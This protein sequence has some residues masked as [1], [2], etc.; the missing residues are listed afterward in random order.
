MKA[1]L[2]P[3]SHNDTRSAIADWMELQALGSSRARATSATLSNVLDITEDEAAETPTIDEETGEILDE[4]ILEEGRWSLVTALFEE[5]EYR[6]QVLGEAYPFAVD[7]RRLIL[8]RTPVDPEAQA[9]QVVYLFC[10]LASAIREKKLKLVEDI[11]A[12]ERGIA[13]AFQICACLAAGGYISGEVTSFG[14]PRQT[15]DGF[16]PALRDAY[17]R[18][19]IGEVRAEIPDGLPE[20]LKDGG[21]DVIAWRDHPDGMPG[22]IYLLGQCA[23]GRNWKSKSVV[24]YIEQLHGSWFTLQPASHS[25]PAMFIPFTFHCDMPEERRGPFLT[26][27]KNAYWY[28]EKRFGIIFDRLRIAHFAHSCMSATDETR[29]R[30]DGVDRFANVQAW[31]AQALHVFGLADAAA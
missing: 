27:V 29:S 15:G 26:A 25:M 18:F 10:L 30:V 16:L 31:V 8:D 17:H 3:P 2:T 9:G 1:V 21:I 28:H 20:S 6:R 22:K 5:L 23:S 7:S 14:F 4:A 13:D 19:G 24:E 12:T 11:D